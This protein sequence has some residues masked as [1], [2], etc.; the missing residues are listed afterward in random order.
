MKYIPTTRITVLNDNLPGDVC[1]SQHG[2]S[3]LVKS[4]ISFLFDAGPSDIIL[5]NSHILKVNLDD[6]QLIVISHGHYDH[7][8]GLLFLDRKKLICHPAALEPKHRKSDGSWNGLP[9]PATEIRKRFRVTETREPLWLSPNVVF[10]G[11][12]PR[13]TGFESTTTAFMTA[14]GKDDFIPDDSGVAII[15]SEGLVVISGCAHAGICNI[16]KH[17]MKVTG[18]EKVFAVMG[19]FHLKEVDE[20]TRET[21]RCLKEMQ[22]RQVFPSHCTSMEARM[23]FAREWTSP[24][25]T[26]GSVISFPSLIIEKD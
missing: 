8:G 2:L 26:S 7:T 24:I 16:V 11:E 20:V 10:L 5:R 25:I 1:G 9:L 18:K 22:V 13:L 19:G 12:I 14:D 6:I 17:A 15:T 23:A 3:F 21:I 4:D